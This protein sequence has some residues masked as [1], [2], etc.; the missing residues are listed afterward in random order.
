M[1]IIPFAMGFLIGYMLAAEQ[2]FED[3]LRR[4]KEAKRKG[5]AGRA[6]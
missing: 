5:K 4:A 3:H 6:W 2:R 1:S